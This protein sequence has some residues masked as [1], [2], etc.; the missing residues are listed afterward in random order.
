VSIKVLEGEAV[1][2]GEVGRVVAAYNNII[3]ALVG[4]PYELA[5]SAMTAASAAVLTQSKCTLEDYT[6]AVAD[7]L[8]DKP[9]EAKEA[10]SA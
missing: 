9:W 4:M 10:A 7:A 6:E 8:V 2:E 3:D 5:L 1:T